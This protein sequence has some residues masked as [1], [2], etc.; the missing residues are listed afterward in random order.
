MSSTAGLFD[1]LER[2]MRRDAARRLPRSWWRA[3][4]MALALLLLCWPYTVPLGRLAAMLAAVVG[5]LAGERANAPL[6]R[7]GR[8]LRWPTVVIGSFLVSVLGWVLSRSVVAIGWVAG[9]LGP[10]ATYQIAE[11]LFWFLVPLGVITALRYGASRMAWLGVL[12]IVVAGGG[13]AASVAAHRDG[14]VNRPLVL[15]DWAWTHGID[16]GVLLLALGGVASLVLAALLLTGR[17]RVWRNLALLAV[18][19]VA[20]LLL[21]R[22]VEAP[23]PRGG[24]GLGLTGEPIDGD[25]QENGGEGGSEQDA[26]E[27]GN[28]GEPGDLE[29][30]DDYE[31]GQGNQ[32]PVA[33]VVFHDEWEPPSGVFYFR[34]SAFS[35]YNGR[36]LIQALDESVDRDIVRLFPTEP[37]EIAEV[38]PARVASRTELPVTIGLMVDHVRPFAL[39]APLSI[40]P[41]V[42][43]NPARF[44]RAF[45]VTSSVPTKGWDDLLGRDAG[46]P[47]WD[48]ATWRHY[49]EAPSD[50][51][52][53]A[54]ARRLLATIR[55]DYRDD[56]LARA[57]AVKRY[58]DKN[59]IYSLK[60]KHAGAGDPT[61]SFLFGDLTGYFVHFAHAATYL[62]RGIGLPARVATGY[63]VPAD[64][65]AGG[66]ALMIRG[67]N[68]HAWPELYL[69]GVGWVT[70]D[71]SPEQ[72]LDDPSAPPDPQLQRMLGEMLRQQPDEP[73]PWQE[74]RGVDW[75]RFGQMGLILLLLLVALGYGV[76]IYRQ[77]MPQWASAPRLGRVGYRAGLDQLAEVGVVRRF[78]ESRE[79]FARRA[80]AVAPAFAELSD[81]HLR[82]AFGGRR[83]VDGGAVRGSLAAVRDD[84]DRQVPRWRRVLGILHPVPWLWAR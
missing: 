19:A 15:G 43:P 56:P 9:L 58:L 69:D 2:P 63:A 32:A 45:A 73:P 68:A 34:Q 3:G 7:D 84:L 72:F 75:G 24:G 35:Q 1:D 53:G 26:A 20:V 6:D 49:T 13:V 83:P 40:A 22:T 37:I 51:R 60:S 11:A 10:L 28:G 33:V 27:G 42:N 18:L 74:A 70:V 36:R 66:S 54:L 46:D 5:V 21:V 77:L 8:T 62:L 55:E 82:W 47:E 39:D 23:V 29:F 57:L 64:T 50:R 79:R 14:L 48:E 12:E 41:M 76:K 80:G 16:P 52:Y 17:R 61:A 25:E 71:P 65:R 67:T 44:Q 38:P 4:I 31:G 78:G 81:E 59:G 30:R